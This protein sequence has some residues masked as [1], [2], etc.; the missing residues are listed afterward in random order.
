METGYIREFIVLAEIGNYHEA[1][2]RLFISQSA[3]SKHIKIVEQELGAAL[4]ERTARGVVLNETG[5][6]FLPYA[7][8]TLQLETRYKKEIHNHICAIDQGVLVGTEYR[9]LAL[10]KEFRMQ[11]PHY[12]VHS[13]AGTMPGEVEKFLR[14]GTCELGF[15]CNTEPSEEEFVLLPYLRDEFAVAFPAAHPLAGRKRVSLHELG[16]QE[17]VM[18]PE[19]SIHASLC[20]KMCEEHEFYP[21]VIFNGSGTSDVYQAVKE[22]MGISIL[23]KQAAEADQVDKMVLVD[24][25]ESVP[26]EIKICYRKNIR[27]SPAAEQFL[28]F[29]K[30]SG[31]LV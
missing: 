8:Q 30:E 9:I 22:N 10:L 25:D 24:L 20:R 26:I 1:A 23:F 17:F 3:L 12:F 14:M 7:R 19:N 6:L 27:L 11:H 13:L 16:D 4:F 5:N 18:M 2:D 15:I 31:Q 21:R 29:I 28:A